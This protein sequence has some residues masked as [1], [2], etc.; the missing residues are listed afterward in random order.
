MI[1]INPI[2]IVLAASLGACIILWQLWRRDHREMVRSQ[3]NQS[4][5]LSEVQYWKLKD[6]S[7]AASIGTMSLT[8][9]ELKEAS[10]S[11][12][13][14]L[15]ATI[16]KLDL[17]IRQVKNASSVNFESVNQVNTFLRDSIILDTVPIKVFSRSTKFNDIQLTVWPTREDSLELRVITRDRMT[18]VVY[19][20]PRGLKFWEKDWWRKRKLRQVVHFENPDTRISYPQYIEIKRNNK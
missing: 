1:R 13:M 12:L 10:D 2:Y 19:K 15:K 3:Q 18:Q 11:Q 14:A 4:T 7:N 16:E 17:R 20:V 5:L 8:V 9:Q 6:S